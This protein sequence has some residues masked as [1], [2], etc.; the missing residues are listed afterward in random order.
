MT[1]PLVSVIIPV[2]NTVSTLKRAVQSVCHQTYS[3]VE[4]ILIDDSSTDGSGGFVMYWRPKTV[5]FA[6]YIS[7]LIK[8]W[9]RQ[10]TEL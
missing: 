7:P 6:L 3:N 2:F 10:D 9:K 4:L 1:S 5:A 8:A